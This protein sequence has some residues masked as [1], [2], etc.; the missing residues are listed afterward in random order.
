MRGRRRGRSLFSLVVFSMAWGWALTMQRDLWTVL[1]PGMALG[2]LAVSLARHVWGGEGTQLRILVAGLMVFTIVFILAFLP[3]VL[4]GE[5]PA[6]VYSQSVPGFVL[7]FGAVFLGWLAWWGAVEALPPVRRVGPAENAGEAVATAT[8]GICG[9]GVT[10]EVRE[11]CVHQCGQVFHKGC[12]A[13][14]VSVYR[15]DSR[16]CAVCNAR[17]A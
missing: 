4:M 3:G 17:V 16:F 13:A 9:Q 2:F 12:Y 7:G 15:G 5:P 14:R 8:C 6:E 11:D 1:A 10:P